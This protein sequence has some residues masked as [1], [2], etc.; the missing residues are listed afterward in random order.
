MPSVRR[1]G[2]RG[3]SAA[4]LGFVSLGLLASAALG[5]PTVAAA[6]SPTLTVHARYLASDHNL[7]FSGTALPK[8]GRMLAVLQF[9][10]E[11]ESGGAWRPITVWMALITGVGARWQTNGHYSSQLM[12]MNEPVPA[13]RLRVEMRVADNTGLASVAYSNPVAVP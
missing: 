12:A 5:R 4:L 10:L 1:I 9:R 3:L 7:A 11:K 2:P 13:G 8:G 6:L